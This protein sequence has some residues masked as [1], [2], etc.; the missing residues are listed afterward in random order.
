QNPPPKI[1]G[2]ITFPFVIL[3]HN[4]HILGFI[5]LGLS[6]KI[7]TPQCCPILDSFFVVAI[8]STA[9]KTVLKMIDKLSSSGKKAED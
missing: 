7:F 8:T 6:R 5:F 1:C 2:I 4:F 9:V 3:Y